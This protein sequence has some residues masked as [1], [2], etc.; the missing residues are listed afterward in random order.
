MTEAL[1]EASEGK[2][3]TKEESVGRALALLQEALEIVDSIGAPPEIGARLQEV[4]DS[5]EDL[6]DRSAKVPLGL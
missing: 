3:S 4:I 2:E 6:Q 1:S 5:L